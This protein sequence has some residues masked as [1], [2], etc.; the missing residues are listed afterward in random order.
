M[1]SKKLPGAQPVKTTGE[2]QPSGAVWRQTA[3]KLTSERDELLDALRLLWAH[4]D[5]LQ[6]R[7]PGYMGKLFLQ[8]YALWAESYYK[9]E[10]VLAKYQKEKK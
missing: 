10:R 2:Y 4:L 8:D 7:N 6:K 3:D 1:T 5:D 9:A